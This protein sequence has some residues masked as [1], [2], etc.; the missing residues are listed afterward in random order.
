M[1]KIIRFFKVPLYYPTVKERWGLTI[2]ITLWVFLIL[3]TLQPFGLNFAIHRITITFICTIII[4]FICLFFIQ[5]Q[6]LFFERYYNV[7]DKWDSGKF[8]ILCLEVIATYVLIASFPLSSYIDGL[9]KF[10][11]YTDFSFF[12]R[13]FLFFQISI[14][15]AVF[16]VSIIYYVLRKKAKP[17]AGKEFVASA[18]VEEIDDKNPDI[19]ELTGTTKDY[20][21]LLPAD[22]LYAEVEGNYVE[23]YY[24]KDGE[25]KHKM[26]RM[27]MNQLMDSLEEYSYIIRCHRAFVV[28]TL[29]VAKVHGNLKRY[30][31][32][33]ENTEVKIPVSKSYT[34]IVKEKV[35][36]MHVGAA[37]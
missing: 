3:Y 37:Y 23:I 11:Y 8:L 4:F 9:E 21:R 10:T 33:L 30:Y 31:L 29:K 36:H 12:K 1:E 28:N 17:K 6:P 13:I 19:I 14:F 2:L 22:I 35:M 32:E 20:V 18:D 5:L 26:L 24:L 7:A 15:V 16:P 25:L 27:S 34:R